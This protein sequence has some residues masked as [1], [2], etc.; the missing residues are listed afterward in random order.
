MFEVTDV[1]PGRPTTEPVSGAADELG[2]S[3]PSNGQADGASAP[4]RPMIAVTLLT[5]HP[6][7]VRRDLDLNPDFLASIKE[8]GVLVPLRITAD[9]D[10]VYRVIDGHRRLAAAV[11]AD[12]AEVPV[13]MA[14]ER[15]ADEPG[16]FIDMWVAHRHR[17]PLTPLEEADAL[18]AA[19]EA[20]ATKARIRK[21]TGL[22]P[23]QVTAA[24]AAATLSGETRASVEALPRELTLEDLAVLAEFE[25]DADAMDQLLNAARW[26]GTLDHQ[27]ER[28]RQEREDK[29]EHE[30]LRHELEE[31][32]VTVTEALPPGGQPL[33]ALSHDDEN[34]TPELHVGCPGRGAF[35]R[36]YDPTSPV[37]YC[38]DPAAHGHSFRQGESAM[39]SG[40][41]GAADAAGPVGSREYGPSDAARRL[42]IQGN[43]AWKAAA[44]VRKR[45]LAGHLFPR[46]TA[47]REVAQFVA[48]QLLTMPDPLRSGLAA[49]TSR[50]LFAEISGKTANE[51]EEVCG[52]V[53]A[54][55]L[56]LLM[57]A[58]I[59]TAYEQ[60]MTEG[61][62]KN[63]WRTDRYSPCPRQEAGRYLA[64][65]A[66]VG[67]QPS[68]IEQAVLDG[69]PYAGD[70]APG[71]PS[72][73]VMDGEA[74]NGQSDPGPGAER[75]P[76]DLD[77]VGA[78]NT[79]DSTG[80]M[81]SGTTA[82]AA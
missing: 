61:E 40:P 14:D 64:F 47:P 27:A 67:Y 6:G 38:A 3:S 80:D 65:L 44:E 26:H 36:P 32:G 66:S 9:A 20:G 34:L 75:S 43:K 53:A 51:W 1:S 12:L 24:L 10:G 15:A 22:K 52:T 68:G 31:G 45:W 46:R 33:A 42:V 37:Y 7:N 23:P 28:L 78:A 70:A 72:S 29:A 77:V 50:P 73:G 71:E 30:R 60:A 62:G 57:L 25:G 58:P 2:D 16:Q 17:N 56:L 49:A 8:N 35:F 21:S 59:A 18:F 4:A 13:D 48:Q 79:P 5:A 41:A 69:A 39:G 81:R 82:A 63:T 11:Q 19:R 54:G 74:T 76:N 55:R